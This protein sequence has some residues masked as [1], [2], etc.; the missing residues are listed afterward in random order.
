M[1]KELEETREGA[2]G[3]LEES[4]SREWLMTRPAMSEERAKEQCGRRGMSHGGSSRR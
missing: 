4:T 3:I 2:M 1:S